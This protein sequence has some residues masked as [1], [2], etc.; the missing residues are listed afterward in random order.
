MPTRLVRLELLNGDP[1]GLRIARI[2][3]RTTDVMACPW[4]DL[5]SLL[6][7]DNA[8]LPAVYVLV[9]VKPDPK[10]AEPS[11]AAYIGQCNSLSDR[12]S[13]KHHKAEDAEW[14]LVLLASMRE[15]AFNSAHALL[16]EDRLTRIARE[17][18]RAEI[19]TKQTSPGNLS[20]GDVAFAESFVEDV[21]VLAQI[22]GVAIFRPKVKIK[23]SISKSDTE[24]PQAE[25]NPALDIGEIEWQFSYTKEIIK[26]RMMT[27]G[28]KFV[29]LSGS[30]VRKHANPKLS[31]FAAKQQ[32]LAF[33]SGALVEKKD[34]GGLIF[35]D[36]FVTSSVS[37]AGAVVYGSNCRGP[38]A[39]FD[40][41]TKLSYRDR[42]N[43]GLEKA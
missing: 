37:A 24:S 20:K 22:M 13:G 28:S 11:D 43:L 35:V 14:T 25:P 8:K 26:A 10:S 2:Q 18:G 6:K 42:V 32:E 27:D 38:D 7:E 16:A 30:Q 34:G 12:F 39:W 41:T 21:T 29:V 5:P 40:P 15:D 31:P 36:D 17:A 33:Q 19:L 3:G 1:D 23:S 4:V 9:G